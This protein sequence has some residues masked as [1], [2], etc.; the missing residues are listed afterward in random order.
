M[1]LCKICNSR[2]HVITLDKVVRGAPSAKVNHCSGCDYAFLSN[3]SFEENFYETEFNTFMA[4]R[5]FDTSWNRPENH[6]QQ[7]LAQGKDRLKRLESISD[8]KSTGSLLELGSSTGFLLQAFKESYPQMK[9]AGVEPG[10]T[11][12]DFSKDKGF[13]TVKDL[14]SLKQ[15]NFDCMVSYFVLEHIENPVLWV[16]ELYGQI[17]SGGKM[18]F[19]VPN[20]NEALVKAYKDKN[21]DQFVWQAPHL[22]YFSEKALLR[23]FQTIDPNIKCVVHNEQRYGLSNHLNW[24]MGIKPETTINFPH[25]TKEID[26]LYAASLE[27]SGLAD[28][29]IGICY[30]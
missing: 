19:V 23:L 26:H 16:K 5:S 25:I 24:L 18:I 22:S 14:K 12:R 10:E 29:L 30:K 15:N 17:K 21:Y 4:E 13:E 6:F 3:V 20:L 28:S 27:S 2:D 1:E 11:Y 7:R 9:L 8:F